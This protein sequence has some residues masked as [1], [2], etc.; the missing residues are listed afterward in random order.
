MIRGFSLEP[1]VS[2][3]F[4]HVLGIPF[5]ER[6]DWLHSTRL[7]SAAP[8]DVDEMNDHYTIELVDRIKEHGP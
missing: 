6:R 2:P 5:L 1:F 3:L 8:N 7:N 4:F